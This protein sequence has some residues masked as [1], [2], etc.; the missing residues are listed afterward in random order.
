V[1]RQEGDGGLRLR[2]MFRA[3]RLAHSSLSRS[4]GIRY[5]GNGTS[6]I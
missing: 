2:M 1:M 4:T 5:W 6:H 3:I